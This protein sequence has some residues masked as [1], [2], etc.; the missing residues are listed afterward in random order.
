MAGVV[1][2]GDLKLAALLDEEGH[3]A[4]PPARVRRL[5]SHIYQGKLR[6]WDSSGS[7]HQSA[8]CKLESQTQL[9]LPYV[10]D[11]CTSCMPI[12][13]AQATL[14]FASVHCQLGHVLLRLNGCS[15]TVAGPHVAVSAEKL[16]GRGGIVHLALQSTGQKPNDRH[17]ILVTHEDSG[18][19]V[20]NFRCGFAL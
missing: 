4:F 10:P 19:S 8:A 12:C 16:H 2:S 14:S 15:V 3:L 20:W 6:I 18:V 7:I 9:S 17:V 5:E 13:Y 11:L 1:H